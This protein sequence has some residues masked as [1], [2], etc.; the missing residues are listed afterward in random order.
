MSS[1]FVILVTATPLNESA[2][3]PRF[4]LG[5]VQYSIKFP[6]PEIFGEKRL[7]PVEPEGFTGATVALASCSRVESIFWTTSSHVPKSI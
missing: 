3:V 4:D 1:D 5:D 7:L 2:A 6:K